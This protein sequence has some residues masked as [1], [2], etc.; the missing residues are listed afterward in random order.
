MIEGRLGTYLDIRQI[1]TGMLQSLI[2]CQFS[3]SFDSMKVKSKSKEKKSKRIED[4]KINMVVFSPERKLQR[5]KSLGS[6]ETIQLNRD[7]K[8]INKKMERDGEVMFFERLPQK[9]L[10]LTEYMKVRFFALIPL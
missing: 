7:V 8:S 2:F 1:P 9:I 5:K 4:A 6:D 10:E 3:V